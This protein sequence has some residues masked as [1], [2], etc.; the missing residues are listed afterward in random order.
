MIASMWIGNVLLFLLNMP[1]IG[2]WVKL[3]TVPYRLLYPAILLVGCLGVYSV[4]NSTFDVFMAAAF[5]LLGYSFVRLECDRTSFLLGFIL[6]PL[7]EENL[8]RAM[9]FSGGDATVFVRRPISLALLLLGA[10]L[11]VAMARPAVARIRNEALG[12]E[13]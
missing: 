4:S 3:L 8:R 9:I 1:L 6:G 11:V 12:V 5:G 2:L 10:A 13:C 7:L